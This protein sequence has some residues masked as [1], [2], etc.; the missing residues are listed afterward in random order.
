MLDPAYLEQNFFF[1][2]VVGKRRLRFDLRTNYERRKYG[3]HV[4]IPLEL[5]KSS[6]LMI[7]LLL[8]A[9]T[10]SEVADVSVLHTRLK[11]SKK[12]PP[13][14]MMLKQST[15]LLPESF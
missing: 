13:G 9:Y 7:H 10:S 6:E 8:S 4:K 1:V 15:S 5:V 11:M 12:I 3:L 14:W 2:S